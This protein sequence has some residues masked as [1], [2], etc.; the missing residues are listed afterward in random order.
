[1]M[2]KIQDILPESCYLREIDG[3]GT[4]VFFIDLDT[5]TAIYEGSYSHTGYGII[6]VHGGVKTELKIDIP[7]AKAEHIITHMLKIV[8]PESMV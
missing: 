3:R 7:N 8:S 2:V 4:S 6:V 5:I 1:M